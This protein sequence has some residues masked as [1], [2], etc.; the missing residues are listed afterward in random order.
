MI[1]LNL[2][3]GANY[4]ITS[5]DVIGI[6]TNHA[7]HFKEQI[8]NKIYTETVTHYEPVLRQLNDIT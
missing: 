2:R 7:K 5:Y 4:I 6:N 1:R 3:Q 8:N